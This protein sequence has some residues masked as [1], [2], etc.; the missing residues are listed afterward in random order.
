VAGHTRVFEPDTLRALTTIGHEAMATDSSTTLLRALFAG[1]L[2]ALIVWLLP[3]AE[4]ARVWVIFAITYVVALAGFPQ[5]VTTAVTGFYLTTT[6]SV[7]WGVALTSLL[8]P[9]LIGN[10]AGGVL[11]VAVLNHA[12]VAAD[13]WSTG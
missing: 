13:S 6:G 10:I 7:D 4:A 9:T 1:W 12:Q 2:V 11:L 3:F 5:I 8:L